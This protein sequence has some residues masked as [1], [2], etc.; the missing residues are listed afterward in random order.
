[1]I[2]TPRTEGSPGAR[3][4]VQDRSMTTQVCDEQR[5]SSLTAL[6][7]RTTVLAALES[8]MSMLNTK[9]LVLNR[10]YLPVHV[11]SVKRAFILLYQDVARAVDEQYRTFDFQSWSELAVVEHD[12]VG[13]V[14]R[15]VRVPRVIL[16]VAFDRV[17]KR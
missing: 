4:T 11:T 13:L 2:A 16:L 9:V 15:I 7:A 14:S 5:L 3:L 17:P 12:S 8:A 1:A 10:S 6:L